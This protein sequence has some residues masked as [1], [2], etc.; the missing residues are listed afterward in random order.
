[1][2]TAEDFLALTGA[3][4]A[5]ADF[6]T[7]RDMVI[8]RLEVAL[9]RPLVEAERTEWVEYWDD[10]AVYPKATPIVSLGDDM[11]AWDHTDDTV[12]LDGVSRAGRLRLTYT[13]GFADYGSDAPNACPVQ[14]AAAIAWG[15]HTSVSPATPAIPAGIQSLNIAGE[16]SATR[17][18]NVILG[19]D[20]EELPDFAQGIA[21]LGGRC[22]QM[23][24]PYR[25]RF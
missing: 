25:R 21:D 1:M 20:S 3:D 5:P 16:W 17:A 13:G 14:L 23:A 9:G 2:I 18:G 22:A 12:L 24:A 11:P 19:A 8:S 4:S 10:G 15:V 7:L 6:E